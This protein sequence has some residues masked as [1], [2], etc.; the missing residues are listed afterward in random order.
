MF[1]GFSRSR[2]FFF[3]FWREGGTAFSSMKISGKI[4]LRELYLKFLYVG[5]GRFLLA[6]KTTCSE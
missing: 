3:F 4:T 6:F 5:G 2:F 1:G